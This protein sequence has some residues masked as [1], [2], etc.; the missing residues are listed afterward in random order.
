MLNNGDHPGQSSTMFLP[1]V[2]MNSNDMTCVNSTLHFVA[3]HAK[4]YGATPEF[5]FDQLLCFKATTIVE[6]AREDIDQHPIILRLGGFHTLI[7]CLGSIGLL[8]RRTGLQEILEVIFAGNTVTHTFT[9]NAVACAI[10]GHLL[11]DSALH[12]LLLSSL[13]G[14]KLPLS[15]GSVPLELETIGNI[16]DDLLSS[17]ITLND[18]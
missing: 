1:T 15:N 18:V 3:E 12:T 5:T 6:N 10:H 14:I 16:C 4:R 13:L 8:M 2:D 17:E 7:S 9:G 11:I